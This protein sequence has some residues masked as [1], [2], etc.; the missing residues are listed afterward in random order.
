MLDYDGR[1]W[2]GLGVLCRF[3]GS[4]IPRALPYAIVSLAFSIYLSQN[5]ADLL[6][7]N[8]DSD[9]VFWHPYAHQEIAHVNL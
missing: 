5:R 9:R 1:K 4:A 7:S 6:G 2:M 3:Y 8:N